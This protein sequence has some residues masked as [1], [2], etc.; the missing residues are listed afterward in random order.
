MA[1]I[2]YKHPSVRSKKF[3]REVSSKVLTT[4]KGLV[5]F[6]SQHH[7]VPLSDTQLSFRSGYLAA[8]EDNLEAKKRASELSKRK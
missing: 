3:A 2:F 6:D 7:E 4:Y 5:V 8:C 1:S